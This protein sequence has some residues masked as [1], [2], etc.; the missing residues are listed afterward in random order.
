M[1]TATG[2]T[3]VVSD[4]PSQFKTLK[5]KNALQDAIRQFN[6]KPKRGIKALLDTGII[7]SKAPEDIARF[8]LT[9][10]GLDKALIGEYLGEGDPENIAIMHAFVDLMD[11]TDAKFVTA[12]RT[13]C[14]PSVF[15]VR[16]RRLTDICLS[17]LNVTP[18]TTPAFSPML[19]LPTCLLT[20]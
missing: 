19:T 6:I 1:S 4:D 16:P 13:F 3:A 11:F 5:S 10:E 14:N 7:E 17:L 8:L 18:S 20:L 2:S 9:T 12:L 15:P